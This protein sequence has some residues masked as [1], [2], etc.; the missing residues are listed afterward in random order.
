MDTT[1][2]VFI[3]LFF[4]VG[5]IAMAQA[6]S[7]TNARRDEQMRSAAATEPA[8]PADPEV[9]RRFR[10]NRNIVSAGFA[11]VFV[12]F[13]GMFVA[14]QWFPDGSESQTPFVVAFALVAGVVLITMR[15]WRCPKCGESLTIA[16]R[17]RPVVL[18]IKACPNCRVPFE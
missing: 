16:G 3:V 14:Q 10:R 1:S 5:L 13:A 9:T 17:R 18:T 11:V 8:P 7:R 6:I 2:P 15:L 4:V 12:S